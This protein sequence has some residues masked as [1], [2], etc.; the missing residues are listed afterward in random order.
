M[1]LSFADGCLTA[2][3]ASSNGSVACPP[4]PFTPGCRLSAIL[5]PSL[6]RPCGP[7]F[8]L[9]RVSQRWGPR[10]GGTGEV[11]LRGRVAFVSA[12]K[13]L[14]EPHRPLLLPLWPISNPTC[15]APGSSSQQPAASSAD[16]QHTHHHAF[17]VTRHP[18]ANTQPLSLLLIYSVPG[19]PFSSHNNQNG[20]PAS[21]HGLVR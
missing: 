8:C 18:A 19:E 11:R 21:F 20:A 15:A 16:K 17:A 3:S 14:G 6:V 13:G 5:A 10:H 7:C 9:R 4:S 1:I 12:S 2:E